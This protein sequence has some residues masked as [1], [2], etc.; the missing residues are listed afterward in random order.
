MRREVAIWA[1]GAACGCFL[2]WLKAPSWCLFAD[3]VAFAAIDWGLRRWIPRRQ[4]ANGELTSEQ[5]SEPIELITNRRLITGAIGACL[6]VMVGASVGL[7]MQSDA[8]TIVW[9]A[10]LL[11]AFGLFFGTVFKLTL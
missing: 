4:P 3:A 11:G 5:P 10:I 1:V 7:F 2:L 8:T 6:G 9:L